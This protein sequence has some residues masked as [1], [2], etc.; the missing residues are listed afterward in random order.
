[1]APPVPSKLRTAAVESGLLTRDQLDDVL[2]ALAKRPGTQADSDEISDQE[3]GSR[4][5]LEGFLNRWQVEQLQLG[6]TNFKLGPYRVVDAIGKGGMGHVFKGQH[7]LLGRI[8]AIKV[9][10]K[11][12]STPDAIASFQREIRVQAQLDHPNLVRVYFADHEGET[13]FLVSEYVPGTDL[14]RLVRRH[15]ALSAEVAATIIAQAAE[16]LHYAHRKGLVHR[17]FKPG[18]V[19]VTPDGR[20]KLTDLGLAWFLMDDIGP[21]AGTKPGAVVGTVDYL[22]PEAIREPHVV[23]PVSDIYSLGCTLYYAATGKV[24][25]PGGGTADKIRRHLEEMPLNPLY[26]N[27]D[28]PKEF[29]D[30]IAAMM[31]KNPDRRVPTAGHAAE[32]LRKWSHIDAR[33]DLAQLAR[34]TDHAGSSSPAMDP[35]SSPAMD[36]A[37]SGWAETAAY[38]LDDVDSP[39]A[40]GSKS[41]LQS[42]EPIR[43]SSEDTQPR[44]LTGQSH[45]SKWA[46]I[47]G[48]SLVQVIVLTTVAAALVMA[49]TCAIAFLFT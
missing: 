13:Y 30:V 49:L 28:L 10:P 42:T 48:L 44:P 17:D 36:S 9:L 27:P 43:G 39:S 4:L 14:R 38:D 32:L 19:L 37:A 45:D 25:F 16:G 3:L 33:H 15:G 40:A 34:R 24:P 11:S 22:A 6:H 8:E 21:V 12:K 7:E 29:C 46:Q 18:N 47:G 2:G 26:L 23:R 1:M 20:A 31:E 35:A 5:V 41:G